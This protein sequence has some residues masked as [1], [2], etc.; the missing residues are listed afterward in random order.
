M[1]RP[2]PHTRP[3]AGEAPFGVEEVFFSRTDPRGVIQ[4]GNEVFRRVA[5]FEWSELIG[6]PHKVVRHSDM[7]ARPVSAHVGPAQGREDRC[8]LCEEQGA[9][10]AALLG[11]C[12]RGTR[13]RRIPLG[14][15]QTHERALQESHGGL[16]GASHAGRGRRAEPPP[17]RRRHSW[18]RSRSMATPTTTRSWPMQCHRNWRRGPPHSASPKTS[19]RRSSHYLHATPRTLAQESEGL[20]RAFEAIR[21]VPINLGITAAGLGDLGRPVAVIAENYGMMCREVFDK[22]NLLRNDGT[23]GFATI[24]EAVRRA[25][26]LGGDRRGPARSRRRLRSRDRGVAR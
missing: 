8:G 6:A 14:S 10:R 18:R 7:A 2:D 25:Q 26:V 19:A 9:G 15:D 13:G 20:T 3:A 12:A 4:A 22:L 11:L 24:S 17:H 5:D 16:R 23:G 1:S 21:A